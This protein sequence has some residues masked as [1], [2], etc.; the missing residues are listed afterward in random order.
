MHIWDNRHKACRAPEYVTYN[1]QAHVKEAEL[2]SDP[3]AKRELVQELYLDCERI[4]N[5]NVHT[6]SAHI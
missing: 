3:M 1:H 5:G 4:H 6:F 2:V